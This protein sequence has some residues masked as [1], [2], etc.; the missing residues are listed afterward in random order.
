M[1]GVPHELKA[2]MTEIVIPKLKAFFNPPVLHHSVIRTVGIG[3]SFLAERIQSWEASLPSRFKLAYLPGIGELRL[4]LTGTGRDPEI[5]ASEAAALIER[6]RPLAGEYIYGLGER[7]LEAV[8]GDRLRAEGLTIAA[9]ESCTG[10]YLSH[11]LTS[12]PGSS[13]YFRGSIIPYDNEIK[14]EGL[15]IDRNL[16]ERHG[17]VSEEVVTLMAISVRQKF[18]SNIGVATSGIA[19]PEG[20]TPD[21]PVGT[22]WIALADESQTIARK[23]QLSND[24]LLNIRIASI[25]VLNLV[26]RSL[27][28][29]RS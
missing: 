11:L 1:P 3:E 7:P 25:N 9:A 21:K 19:G 17:A 23:L 24:R 28:R 16:L 2:M 6:L 20:G 14:I 26:R 15:G 12:I 8:V 29:K 22:V 27:P 5:L 13:A 18:G 10:G 4:R